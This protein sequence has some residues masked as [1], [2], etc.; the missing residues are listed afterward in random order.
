MTRLTLSEIME[1]QA[2]FD[3]GHGGDLPF[4]VS[5]GKDNL[6]QLEH[7]IV[8][9]LGELGEFANIVKKVR[10]GDFE[11]EGV[12]QELNEELVDV[13]IY[14][15]KIANQFD[16]DIETGYRNKLEKNRKKFENYEK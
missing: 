13:F 8:C 14:L 16:V 12:K 3:K 2:F 15:I 10:R 5:I 4:F 9:M 1:S 7:L 11:L 6:D